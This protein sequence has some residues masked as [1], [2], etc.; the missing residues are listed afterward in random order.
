MVEG[1]HSALSDPDN[2]VR[3]FGSKAV[4]KLA[5]KLGEKNT[6]TYF[7]FVQESIEKEA[8]PSIE[9]G[10]VA[11]ALAEIMCNLTPAYF[12]EKLQEIFRKMKLPANHMKEG[13]IGV[14]VYLPVILKDKFKPFIKLV[15]DNTVEFCTHE[16]DKVRDMTLRV[17]RILI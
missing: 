6:E 15:L 7:K 13:Y 16:N 3:T 5:E 9:R 10:G 1:L 12:N 8:T 2:D 4:G 11:S 14:F 17:L